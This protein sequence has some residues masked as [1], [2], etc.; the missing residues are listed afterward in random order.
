MR[1]AD[2]A[3]HQLPAHAPLKTGRDFLP[4]SRAKP[5]QGSPSKNQENNPPKSES[6]SRWAIS[7]FVPAATRRA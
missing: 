6:G 7:A 5:Y 2:L 3:G 1:P 4:A